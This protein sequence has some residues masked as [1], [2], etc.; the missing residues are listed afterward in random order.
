MT[1]LEVVLYVTIF[2]VT[3]VV[4]VLIGLMYNE[5]AVVDANVVPD[6]FNTILFAA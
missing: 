5:F 6:A 4:V 1:S 3:P 2:P